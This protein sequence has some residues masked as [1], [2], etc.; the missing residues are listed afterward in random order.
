MQRD[1]SKDFDFLITISDNVYRTKH[2][3]VT[4]NVRVRD[5]EE[6]NTVI[7]SHDTYF[8]RTQARDAGYEKMYVNRFN[9]EGKRVQVG[10]SIRTYVK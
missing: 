4:Q 9:S 7:Y 3:I 1:L 6:E 2:Y 5:D 8:E 10:M